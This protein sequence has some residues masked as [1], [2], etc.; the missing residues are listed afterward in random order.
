MLRCRGL[1]WCGGSKAG[2]V[3]ERSALAHRPLEHLGGLSGG[4][5]GVRRGRRFAR[6]GVSSIGIEGGRK[7]DAR[8]RGLSRS[9]AEEGG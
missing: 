7:I 6:D 3:T 2:L 9:G 5:T 4:S 8:R 1:R